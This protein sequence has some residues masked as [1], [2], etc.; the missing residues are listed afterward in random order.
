MLVSR[1]SAAEYTW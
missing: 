1:E